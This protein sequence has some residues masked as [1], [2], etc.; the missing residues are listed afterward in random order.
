MPAQF[1]ETLQTRLE[2][3]LT[4][5]NAADLPSLSAGVAAR[6][7]QP[8]FKPA[9]TPRGART[10]VDFTPMEWHAKS[11]ER[12]LRRRL[13]VAAGVV[14]LG[15]LALLMLLFG[16]QA[17][18]QQRVRHLEDRL[19]TFKAP[20]EEVRTLQNKVRSFERSLARNRMALE[21]LREISRLLPP[22]TNISSFQFKQGRQL[23][24]RGEASTVNPIYDFKQALDESRIFERTEMGSVQPGRRRNVTVQTFQITGFFPG[25]GQTR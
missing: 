13:A 17:L 2:G 19:A 14:F 1:S 20:A 24:V 15:W 8:P 11:A 21:S 6:M 16:G 9:L 18:E 5:E 7:L 23:I 3:L 10:V 25:S 4:I 22:D 12:L